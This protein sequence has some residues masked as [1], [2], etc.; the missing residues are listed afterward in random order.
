[1]CGLLPTGEKT[2]D[3]NAVRA[4]NM[5]N[6][7]VTA[8]RAC[9]PEYCAAHSI[10][11]VTDDEWDDVLADAEELLEELE[12]IGPD[13]PPEPDGGCFRGREAEAFQA[14]TQARIQR[15]LK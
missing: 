8:M 5:L 7:V 1:M 10:E 4:V 12:A 6:R 13:E 9:D 2:M 11:Q 3:E 14:E 15:T